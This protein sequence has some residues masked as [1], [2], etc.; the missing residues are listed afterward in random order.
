MKQF[1]R[2]SAQS[3]VCRRNTCED[4][5]LFAFSVEEDLG[6]GVVSDRTNLDELK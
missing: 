5:I 2:L 3:C 4:A 6:E 1:F